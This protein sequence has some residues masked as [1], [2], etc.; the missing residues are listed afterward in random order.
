M[1]AHA[2]AHVHTPLPNLYLE[3]GL[4]TE[5][6][7]EDA[8]GLRR[9]GGSLSVPGWGWG[10]AQP[11]TGMCS[12]ALG[13]VCRW[14]LNPGLLGLLRDALCMV[15]WIREAGLEREAQF[16][17]RLFPGCAGQVRNS[18]TRPV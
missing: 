9:P 17:L 2:C 18:Q 4:G 1:H 6:G 12:W 5:G 10:E 13:E 11:G 3:L 14:Q 16:L 8:G 7:E 15:L